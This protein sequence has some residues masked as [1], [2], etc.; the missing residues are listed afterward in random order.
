MDFVTGR[1]K[2]SP[3]E[4]W[5][6]TN[7]DYL[8]QIIKLSQKHPNALAVLLC[9]IGKMDAINVAM[10]THTALAQELGIS[11]PTVARSIRALKEC[12]FVG[13]EK[14]GSSNVYL[15]NKRLFWQSW[16]GKLEKAKFEA[17]VVI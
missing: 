9:L 17:D 15:I 11:E 4:R 2:K 16:R 1:D 7:K 10:C 14:Q 13:I 3:Y 6:Q 8:P 12:G 5:F